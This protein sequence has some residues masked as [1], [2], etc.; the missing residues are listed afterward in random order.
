MARAPFRGSPRCLGAPR[1]AE[2]EIDDRHKNIA[3]A[4]QECC[5]LAMMSVVRMALE[6][7]ES[8]QLVPGRRSGAEFEGERQD[9]GVGNGRE[10][11]RSARSV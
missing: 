4:V 9:S 2:S 6:K 5:E 10:D 3:Y 8:P 11:F 7:T 1:A